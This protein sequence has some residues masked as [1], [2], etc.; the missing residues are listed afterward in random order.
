LKNQNNAPH[1]L[2]KVPDKECDHRTRDSNEYGGGDWRL[3]I[4]RSIS[5]FLIGL[6]NNHFLINV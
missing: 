3:S 2:G 6:I 4:Y 1:S 5:L